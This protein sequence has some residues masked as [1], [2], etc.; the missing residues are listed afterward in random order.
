MEFGQ[1]RPGQGV[2]RLLFDRLQQRVARRRELQ[3]G[4]QGIRQRDRCG[5]RFRIQLDGP[6]RI[7]QCRLVFIQGH[8]YHRAQRI[9]GTGLR[10]LLQ[11]GIDLA[12][13][14]VHPTHRQ[15]GRA[16][17][18]GSVRLAGPGES[19]SSAAKAQAV[20]PFAAQFCRLVHRRR[21]TPA[22]AAVDMTGG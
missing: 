10:I 1:A 15:Q 22:T 21:G 18:R 7:G 16:L 13:R 17:N 19:L 6:T 14:L 5:C 2:F 20:S 11:G 12:A 3:I 9:S 4:L 8:R